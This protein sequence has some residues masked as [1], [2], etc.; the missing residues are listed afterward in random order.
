MWLVTHHTTNGLTPLLEGGRN[1]LVIHSLRS[2]HRLAD[3][4]A[5]LDEAGNAA[6]I[7][8][9]GLLNSVKVSFCPSLNL[10]HRMVHMAGV[11]SNATLF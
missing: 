6:W 1:L 9:L 11:P 3:C 5:G 4:S 2:R 7:V 10:K 8:R